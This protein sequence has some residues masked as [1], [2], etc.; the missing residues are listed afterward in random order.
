MEKAK[1]KKYN[2]TL[3]YI[4]TCIHISIAQLFT[5]MH[6]KNERTEQNINGCLWLI[7]IY[8]YLLFYSLHIVLFF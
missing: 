5:Y 2:D 4:C 1:Y 8:V 3:I 7:E 6:R